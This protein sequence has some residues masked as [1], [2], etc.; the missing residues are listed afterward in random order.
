MPNRYL[1]PKTLDNSLGFCNYRLSLLL[2]RHLI[3]TIKRYGMTPEQ[4]QILVTVVEAEKPILS[5]Y[6]GYVTLQ[7]RH[8]VSRMLD[9]MVEKKWITKKM[10]GSRTFALTPTPKALFQF[11]KIKKAVIKSFESRFAI[12]DPK[13]RENYIRITKILID[14]FQRTS[15][16]NL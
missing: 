3:K 10:H 9:R 8:S 4:W 13:E 15:G 2:K 12:L 11:N 7:D 1:I 5:S 16:Q 6:I 14:T